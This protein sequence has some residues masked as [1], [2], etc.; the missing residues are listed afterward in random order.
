[1][2]I[3]QIFSCAQT[4][5]ALLDMKCLVFFVFF[6]RLT[7]RNSW[8]ITSW[9]LYYAYRPDIKEYDENQYHFITLI[10]SS[11]MMDCIL[12]RLAMNKQPE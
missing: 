5:S 4:R 8:T 3:I 9:F 7:F 6:D 1:M 2:R 10:L 12:L 11:L